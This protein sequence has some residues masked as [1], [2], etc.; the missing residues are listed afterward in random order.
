MWN[1]GVKIDF[2]DEILEWDGHKIPL[3]ID[4]ALQ[5]KRICLMLY[6]MHLDLPILKETEEQVKKILDSNY[7]KVDINE[8]VDGLD[9]GR[10]S[11]RELKK[12]LKSF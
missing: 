12:T 8:M 4:G 7:S 9:I 1:M 10:D 5:D 3:K 2:R 6:T 11:K